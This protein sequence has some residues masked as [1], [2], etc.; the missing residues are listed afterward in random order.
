MKFIELNHVIR[1]GLV[2]YPGMPPVEISALYT[3]KQCGQKFGGESAALLD[4]I[5]MVNISGTY[6]DSP[7]HRFEE[8]YKICDI[9]LEKCFDLP[10]FVVDLGTNTDENGNPIFDTD[11][12][13]VALAGKTLSGSAVLLRSG[14]GKKF[15]T[16]QYEISVPYCTVAAAEWLMAQ[17][18][19]V[20]G[21]DTEL[22]DD[23]NDK[24]KGDRVHDVVLSAGS[25]I[26]EDMKDLDLLPKEGAHLYVI[27]PRVEM[28]SFPARVFAVLKE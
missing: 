6:I 9:P 1:N 24:S 27:A 7:Y 8:G 3:R 14:H 10:T 5:R 22:V 13:K 19:F 25:V 28:A 16:P 18:V 20:L 11:D 17:G 2:S 23:F 4:Q 21:I 26:C 12:V 15:M